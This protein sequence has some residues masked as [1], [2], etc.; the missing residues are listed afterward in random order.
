MSAD[1]DANIKDLAYDR[2]FSERG[3]LESGR[4]DRGDNLPG[5]GSVIVLNL[6]ANAADRES[7]GTC[8]LHGEFVGDVGRDTAPFECG[9]DKVSLDQ[10]VDV[11]DG[12]HRLRL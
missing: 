2:A 9:S 4:R 1:A 10:K 12:G 3:I 8:G 7:V 6:H 5:G 11:G